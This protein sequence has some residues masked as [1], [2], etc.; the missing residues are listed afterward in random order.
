MKFTVAR[1][2]S[3]AVGLGAIVTAVLLL[4]SGPASSSTSGTSLPSTVPSSQI[5]LWGDNVTALSGQYPESWTAAVTIA[6]GAL[7]SLVGVPE[8]Q[9]LEATTTEL[10]TFSDPHAP[11]LVNPVP[12]WMVTFSFSTAIQLPGGRPGS[13]H[14]PIAHHVTVFVSAQT[15]RELETDFWP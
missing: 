14:Y 11:S 10:V 2:G 12:A 13:G 6:E 3:V 9:E 1:I 7:P 15:G 5:A 8:A 4:G